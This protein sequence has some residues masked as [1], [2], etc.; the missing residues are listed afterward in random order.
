[1]KHLSTPNPKSRVLLALAGLLILAVGPGASAL[2]AVFIT[3]GVYDES[4]QTNTI[5]VEGTLDANPFQVSSGTFTANVLSAFGTGNGGVIDF[6]SG[7]LTNV[8]TIDGSFSS[9]TKSISITNG[10]GT[11]FGIGAF[12]ERTAISGNDFLAVFDK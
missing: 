11:Y 1:M 4:I 2:Q 12:S 8:T 10:I 3:G 5:D 9:G 7:S 6:D